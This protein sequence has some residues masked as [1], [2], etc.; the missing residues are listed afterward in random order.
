LYGADLAGGALGSLLAGLAL[1]PM[2]GLVPTAWLV[3]A[4]NVMAMLLV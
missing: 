4:L 2:A 3:V 1:V